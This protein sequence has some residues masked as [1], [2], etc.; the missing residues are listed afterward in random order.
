MLHNYCR[1]DPG[2]AELADWI[3]FFKGLPGMS[4]GLLFTDIPPIIEVNNELT[5]NWLDFMIVKTWLKYPEDKDCY[6]VVT[7]KVAGDLNAYMAGGK[8]RNEALGNFVKSVFVN[9]PRTCKAI[10]VP[11]W[12]RG[13]WSLYMFEE[14]VTIHC[15]SVEGF[16]GGDEKE[17]TFRR[18]IRAM[19][20][21]QRGM[22]ASD[23]AYHTF[24]GAPV[25]RPK[26]KQ[27]Y[28]GWACGYDVIAN[29]DTYLKLRGGP[30]GKVDYK[31]VSSL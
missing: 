7:A 25:Y 1:T 3:V 15:D 6:G 8:A 10:V 14:G 31:R 13:H 2:H 24:V 27:S 28:D 18:L 12:D 30:S 16:H 21:E 4:V 26:V 11:Y 22:A 23:F 20:A 29:L 19:W 9:F 17:E 5:D